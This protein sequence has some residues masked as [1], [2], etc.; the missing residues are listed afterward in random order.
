MATS[1]S[2]S[3]ELP[4]GR[5][6]SVRPLIMGAAWFLSA[7]ACPELPRCI[8]PGV[9]RVSLVNLD[10]SSDCLEPWS[11]GWE[12]E[13][14]ARRWDLS[15][16]ECGSEVCAPAEFSILSAP[17]GT[18]GSRPDQPLTSGWAPSGT[19]SPLVSMGSADNQ[20]GGVVR[21]DQTGT[22]TF[23]M[24]GTYDSAGRTLLE[25]A[26]W[27]SFVADGASLGCQENFTVSI[28][29]ISD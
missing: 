13:F 20:V 29:R 16:G 26:Y 28:E 9:Y 21:G 18:I 14:E 1:A 10:P 2:S 4:R 12:V 15:E 23:A 8:E 27:S 25:E 6:R 11:E 19:G 17:E 24:R 3:A 5:A 22:V 7:C